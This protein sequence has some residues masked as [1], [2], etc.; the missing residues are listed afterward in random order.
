MT[1]IERQTMRWC[2]EAIDR[3][4]HHWQDYKNGDSD[5]LTYLVGA[6]MVMSMGEVR[7]GGAAAA[8]SYIRNQERN[9]TQ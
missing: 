7:P 8:F 6:V 1:D 4:E 3:R 5:A 9:D 2:R